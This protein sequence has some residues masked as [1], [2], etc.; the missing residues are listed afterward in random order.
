MKKNK[1][2]QLLKCLL[3]KKSLLFNLKQGLEMEYQ[4]RDICKDLLK[5]LKK[6]DERKKVAAIV[7][8]EKE[9]IAITKNLI[10]IVQKH[11]IK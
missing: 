9:H 1:A 4:A 11:Y 8:D 2:T 7:E 10:K 6:P 3:D 5:Y